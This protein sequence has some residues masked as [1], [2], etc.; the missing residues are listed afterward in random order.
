MK[1]PLDYKK[2]ET[3]K[4]QAEAR[5]RRRRD[6]NAVAAEKTANHDYPHETWVCAAFLHFTYKGGDFALPAGIDRIHV[7][8]SRLTGVKDDERILAK[9][10]RQGKKL[11]EKGAAVYSQST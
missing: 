9:E 2:S 7:A 10:I 5:E 6:E 1:A 11:V 3:A 8:Q 4:R